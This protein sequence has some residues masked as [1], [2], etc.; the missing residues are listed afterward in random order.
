MQRNGDAPIEYVVFD[1]GGVLIDWNPRYL[2][3]QLLPD[4]A[5]EP[6]VRDVV[7]AT[8][9]AQMD[10]GVPFAD[11][12]DER[13]RAYPD[14]AGLIRAYWDRWAE[15][16]GGALEGTVDVLR[17]LRDAEVPVYALT[18]WSAET[19]HHA[20]DRFDF[21]SWFRDIVVSG[22]ERVVKP[23]PAIYRL[24]LDRNDLDPTRGVF[25]D[26]VPKNV[27]GA[28]RVG[29]DAVRFEDPASLRGDLRRRGLPV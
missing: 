3:R 17:E 20:T 5:V 29:L 19:F 15:M 12:L 22:R 9:N 25:V 1:L 10:A 21:L 7:H 11:A 14:H 13:V 16:L 6:F 28:R 26:D 2:Y 8:W 18:N 27:D 23:D 24:L 4:H